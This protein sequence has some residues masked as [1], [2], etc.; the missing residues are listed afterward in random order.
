MYQLFAVILSFLCIPILFRLKIKLSKT[1][2]ITA[3]ILGLLS[4]IGID[5]IKEAVLSVFIDSSSLSTLLAVSM[6]T[7]LSG[8]MKEYGILDKIVES[9]AAIIKNKKIILMIVPALIGMLIVPGGALLSAP[10]INNLGEEMDIKVSRRA[11]INLVF[12]HIAMFVL[13]YST[14]LLIIAGVYARIKY[15]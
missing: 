1:L 6:V 8:L 5:S 11:A 4:G 2:F 13:P 7:I 15:I 9:M 14:S 10:F 3:G 12:R